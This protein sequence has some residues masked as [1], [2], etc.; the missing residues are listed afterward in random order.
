MI[1]E[2]A[3]IRV[4]PDKMVAFEAA[5]AEAMLLFRN[6]LGCRSFRLDRSVNRHGHYT[7]VVG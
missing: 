7:L 6:T 5:V 2:I 4:A 3:D 1:K